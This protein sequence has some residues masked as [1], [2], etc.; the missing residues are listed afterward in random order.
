[1]VLEESLWVLQQLRA[2]T[3]LFVHCAYLKKRISS[4][5]TIKNSAQG[6]TRGASAGI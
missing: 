1:M 6:V 5:G 4:R 3:F 2:F